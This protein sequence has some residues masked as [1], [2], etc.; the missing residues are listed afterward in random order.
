MQ[1]K[2]KL[3]IANSKTWKSAALCY[4]CL[5][6]YA[7]VWQICFSR[8][9]WSEIQLQNEDIKIKGEN[10]WR[11][12]AA[13]GEEQTFA[14]SHSRDINLIFLRGSGMIQWIPHMWRASSCKAATVNQDLLFKIVLTEISHFQNHLFIK[15]ENFQISTPYF[16]F[17]S[18]SSCL[19]FDCFRR[20][21]YYSSFLPFFF[22]LL[23]FLGYLQACII[24]GALKRKIKK[25]IKTQ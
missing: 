15:I 8:F 1:E 3:H 23:Y 21:G 19:V 6:N 25:K 13:W 12:W 4:S 22:F 20:Q 2:R 16:C 17:R 14:P 10:W 5:W 11:G 9:N 18:L 24:F 7:F